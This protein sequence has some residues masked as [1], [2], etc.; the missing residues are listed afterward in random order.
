M[1]LP[2]SSPA[3]SHPRSAG[4]STRNHPSS[5]RAIFRMQ[6][7]HRARSA[8]RC[9][10]RNSH[11]V[12]IRR[13][14]RDRPVPGRTGS[15]AGGPGQRVRVVANDRRVQGT[16]AET[17]CG[18]DLCALRWPADVGRPVQRQP[19]LTH[20]EAP[21]PTAPGAG[22]PRPGWRSSTADRPR[23]GRR[24]GSAR[25][26]ARSAWRPVPALSDHRAASGAA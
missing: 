12:G 4:M 1:R 5:A 15:T 24:D 13:H 17:G 6:Q 10:K 18:A 3:A 16:W 21:I 19:V 11:A 7:G 2:G 26:P 9:R 25:L 23:R 22:V 14:E 8:P 20:H